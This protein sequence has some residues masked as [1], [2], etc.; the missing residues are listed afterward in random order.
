ML[1]FVFIRKGK[2]Q[3]ATDLGVTTD[4]HESSFKINLHVHLNSQSS[5]STWD[6]IFKKF[7]KAI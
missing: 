1:K 2:F 3:Q 5:Y 6:K 4:F 7:N